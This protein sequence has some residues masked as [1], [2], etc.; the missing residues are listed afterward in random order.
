MKGNRKFATMLVL[1]VAC[2]GIGI[3]AIVNGADLIG[4]AG[5]ITA[6]GAGLIAPMWANSQ[7]WKHGAASGTGA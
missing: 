4:A 2:T 3:T 6:L 7:E 1:I 5:L